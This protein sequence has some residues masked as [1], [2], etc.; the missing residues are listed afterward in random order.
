MQGIAKLD[1]PPYSRPSFPPTAKK[2]GGKVM[3]IEIKMFQGFLEND[4]DCLTLGIGQE[5]G[6]VGA[7]GVG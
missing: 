4:T 5:E 3:Y 1:L 2:R 7:T 6:A